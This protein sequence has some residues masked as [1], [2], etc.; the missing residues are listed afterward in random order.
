MTTPSTAD[1]KD[2]GQPV[3]PVAERGAVGPGATHSVVKGE[4]A[5]R[6][7]HERDESSD[8][9]TGEPTEVM[10]KAAEDVHKGHS[11]RPRG[12]QT[13]ADYS[14]LTEKAARPTKPV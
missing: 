3:R 10:H 6:Q 14:D 12:P 13:Q 5:P 9:G 11:D 7:P 8:S 4:V 1:S 2:A